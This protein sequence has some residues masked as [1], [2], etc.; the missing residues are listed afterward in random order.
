MAAG[1]VV[2]VLEQRTNDEGQIRVRIDRGW[3]SVVAASGSE[4]LEREECIVVSIKDI[5]T[6]LKNFGFKV[7]AS[8]GTRSQDTS[9]GV[10]YELVC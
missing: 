10:L 8:P 5:K 9:L 7:C 1:L 6:V 3:L 4:L 2:K